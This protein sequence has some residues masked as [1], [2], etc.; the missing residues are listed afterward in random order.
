[1]ECRFALVGAGADYSR[2]DMREALI[3]RLGSI[4]TVAEA[5]LVA[6]FDGHQ[7]CPGLRSDPRDIGMEVR[8]RSG[9]GYELRITA[10]RCGYP[11]TQELLAIAPDGAST[12]LSKITLQR[13]MCT[14]GR[15]APGLCESEAE[16]SDSAAGAFLARA[17]QL[18]AGSI[19]AFYQ[20]IRE[21]SAHGAPESLRALALDA[22]LDEVAHAYEVAQLARAFGAEVVAAQLRETPLRSLLELAL[23]NAQEGCVRETFGALLA[24][25]QAQV[26]EDARVR[27]AL[28]RIAEDET[29]HAALSWQLMAW[30]TPRLA[31]HEREAV[32]AARREARAR[33]EQESD[34]GLS[35]AER[36]ALG[37]PTP[38][39][40][41]HLLA[42]LDVALAG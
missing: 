23:D 4:D 41:K 1:L 34:F 22:M 17:A 36:R 38:A 16:R 14:I 39:L 11:L 8:T 10:E 5:V 2:I 24:T 25:Y 33:L 18:E 29:R 30:I 12:Q 9:G 6:A 19:Y 31:A 7:V 28:A 32:A 13:A 27:T 35:A 3:A 37:M 42:Q 26:A 15:R 21:L 40:W 20:L